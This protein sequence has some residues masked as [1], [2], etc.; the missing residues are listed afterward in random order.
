MQQGATLNVTTNRLFE[1]TVQRGFK[2]DSSAVPTI[3]ALEIMIGFVFGYV[4]RIAK[5]GRVPAYSNTFPR[6]WR[7]HT[8]ICLVLFLDNIQ[9]KSVG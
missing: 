4:Y 1:F 2:I 6:S 8:S 5:K 3:N 9:K 7:H